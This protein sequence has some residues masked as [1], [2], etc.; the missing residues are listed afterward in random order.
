MELI[1]IIY[2]AL[3]IFFIIMLVTI[4]SSYISYKVKRKVNNSD[5]KDKEKFLTLHK[6]VPQKQK[7]VTK[8]HHEKTRRKEVSEYDQ[9]PMEKMFKKSQH[10]EEHKQEQKPT[11]K[12][13]EEKSVSNKRI[14]VINSMP[15]NP[16]PK[17]SNE[18][19]PELKKKKINFNTLGDD[20]LNKYSDSNDDD[21]HSLNATKDE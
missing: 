6:E 10:K 9:P 16:P 18:E 20:I 12:P 15:G 1:P 13:N 14:N 3:V 4:I 2:T 5:E 7:N 19:K 11:K 8:K 21:F 17:K